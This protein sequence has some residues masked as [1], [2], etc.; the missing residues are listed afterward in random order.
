MRINQD[1]RFPRYVRNTNGDIINVV[2]GIPLAN[3]TAADINADVSPLASAIGTV[4]SVEAYYDPIA[5]ILHGVIVDTEVNPPLP[6]S[7]IT[8]QVTRYEG[9]NKIRVDL[10]LLCSTAAQCNAARLNVRIGTTTTN[11]CL[12]P[13]CGLTGCNPLPPSPAAALGDQFVIVY[14]L[15]LNT[16]FPPSLCISEANSG[17]QKL[18]T[19]PFTKLV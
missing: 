4:I 16:A 1:A 13:I 6:A 10:N 14:S 11:A 17:S 3:P 2:G 5:S 8:L 9:S 15:R 18:L 7:G 12:Q 19:A